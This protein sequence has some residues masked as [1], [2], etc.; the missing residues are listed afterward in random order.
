MQSSPFD[1][2]EWSFL[3][4]Y[5]CSLALARDVRNTCTTKMGIVISKRYQKNTKS[6]LWLLE[7]CSKSDRRPT[8]PDPTDPAQPHIN[9][10]PIRKAVFASL[11]KLSKRCQ[12]IHKISDNKNTIHGPLAARA[13]L[14]PLVPKCI[15]VTFELYFRKYISVHKN[16]IAFEIIRARCARC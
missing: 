10:S 8:R 12:K 1:I 5:Y 9:K 16:W 15:Y 4:Y 7:T 11:F 13:L 3:K 6:P 2:D 14:G